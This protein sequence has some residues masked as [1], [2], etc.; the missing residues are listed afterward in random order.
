[1]VL[2]QR[3]CIQDLD[4]I[5]RYLSERKQRCRKFEQVVLK[6]PKKVCS[7]VCFRAKWPPGRRL[8][9]S[10]I[11]SMKRLEVFLLPHAWDAS[12]SQG[13]PQHYIRQYPFILLGGERHRESKVSRLRTRHHIPGQGS[14]PDHSIRRRA[15]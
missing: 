10:G 11:C 8:T 5:V 15:H 14:S 4:W 6:S 1:M 3:F 13:Y 7:E 9:S 2:S 12:P